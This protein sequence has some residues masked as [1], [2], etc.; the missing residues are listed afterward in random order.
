MPKIYCGFTFFNEL[1]L[2]ELRLDEI[3]PH[4]DRVVLVESPLTF[5]GRPKPLHFAE[6]RQRFERFSRKLH[7]AVCPLAPFDHPSSRQRSS[8]SWEREA[9][10]NNWIWEAVRQLHPEEDDVLVYSDLDEIPDICRIRTQVV[11]G[12]LSVARIS[13]HWFHFGWHNYLGLWND[14]IWVARCGAVQAARHCDIDLRLIDGDTNPEPMGWHL[15]FFDMTPEQVR[16]KLQ[17]YSHHNDDRERALLAAG[18]GEIRRRMAAGG[19]L[20][21]D[22]PQRPFTGPYP[23]SY[24]SKTC[25]CCLDTMWSGTPHRTCPK[26]HTTCAACALRLKRTDCLLCNPLTA[27]ASPLPRTLTHPPSGEMR[28]VLPPEQTLRVRCREYILRQLWVAAQAVLMLARIACIFVGS[29]Y[30]GKVYVWMYVHIGDYDTPAWFGWGSFRY[31]LPEALCGA[32]CTMMLVGC[33][34]KDQ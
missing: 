18:D 23:R 8:R 21:G 13:S 17:S 9:H 5:S 11:P 1:D 31:I 26:G 19:H 3:Y 27:C 16:L 20:F 12:L 25:F 6:N 29:G 14:T 22:A 32:F 28:L 30:L 4:V 7:H 2:L 15:S 24:T 33:C 10:Q 34:V